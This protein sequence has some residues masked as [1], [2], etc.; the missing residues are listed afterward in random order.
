MCGCGSSRLCAT[1]LP[2]DPCQAA[3]PACRRV[4]LAGASFL[5]QTQSGGVNA[6]SDP[7]TAYPRSTVSQV[8]CT[9]GFDGYCVGEKVADKKSDFF[10]TRWLL[11]HSE[12]YLVASAKVADQCPY[13]DLVRE[14]DSRCSDVGGVIASSGVDLS[15]QS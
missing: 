7:S 4:S 3:A 5:A 8:A 2:G 15:A 9:P 6:R 1:G 14:P 12:A 10:D 11:V 13:G